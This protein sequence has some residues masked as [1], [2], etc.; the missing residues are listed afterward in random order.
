[1]RWL[2]SNEGRKQVWI[3]LL[4]VGLLGAM[5]FSALSRPTPDDAEPYHLRVK[6]VAAE[7]PLRIDRWIG[8]DKE[9]TRAA[10]KLLNPNVLFTR[11]YRNLD[12]GRTATFMLVQCKDARDL[13]GHYPPV[14]YPAHGWKLKSSAPKYWHFNE[15]QIP[16]ME[17][18]FDFS[19]L[20]GTRRIVIRNFMILP[21]GRIYR[22]MSGVREAAA[23]Y[24]RHFFGAA[25]IQLVTDA[26]M[27]SPERDEVFRELLEGHQTLIDA[28]R[29]G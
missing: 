26:G 19:R 23:D 14:C 22:D 6:Q 17:Y 9:P 7:I 12:T 18:R 2:V 16:G 27:P 4:S 1:M 29:G 28:L 25:Q 11:R 24:N 3:P 20:E 15:L 8:T 13:A 21:D 10:V 5:G